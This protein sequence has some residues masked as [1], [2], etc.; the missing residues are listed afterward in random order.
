M[1]DQEGKTDHF[2]CAVWTDPLDNC[3]TWG[4]LSQSSPI[5]ALGWQSVM[6]EPSAFLAGNFQ[7]PLSQPVGFDAGWA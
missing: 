2:S 3:H 7:G 4:Q 5:S 6:L 1:P